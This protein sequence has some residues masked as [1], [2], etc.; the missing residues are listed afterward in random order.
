MKKIY[1]LVEKETHS[2]GDIEET[3]GWKDIRI[4]NIV[5]D[6]LNLISQFELGISDNSEKEVS[7]YLLDNL[8]FENDNQFELIQ[9]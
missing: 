2:V 9:L 8:L 3:T 1:Y 4:Y 7:N 6:E 5:N